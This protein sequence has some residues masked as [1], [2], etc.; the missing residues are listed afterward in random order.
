MLKL[1]L[2]YFGHLMWRT[3]SFEKSLVLGKIE[4]GRRRG[5]QRLRWL[6][7][8]T[9]SMDMSLGKLRELVIDREAWHAAV[10]GV[11]KSQT[12]L[13]DW[14]E[15][16]WN[17]SLSRS[18]IKH[19]KRAWQSTSVFL[20]GEYCGQRSLAGLQS[21]R[22]QRVRHDGSDWACTSTHNKARKAERV[23]GFYKGGKIMTISGGLAEWGRKRCYEKDEEQEKTSVISGG[24]SQWT[25][26]ILNTK[27]LE[28]VS[29]KDRKRW[30]E[31]GMLETG[32][33][34]LQSLIMTSSTTLTM[35]VSSCDR[36]EDKITGRRREIREN[37]LIMFFIFY[38]LRC[39][40]FLGHFNL[41]KDWSSQG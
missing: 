33:K 20:P 31:I 5:Q 14:T 6:D 19:W 4:G 37:V 29:Y 3:D 30:L 13:S 39:F 17:H 7:G 25:Q 11:T 1:K 22:S 34:K 10:H 15:L 26:R 12:R 9:E 27:V 18:M 40:D 21:I 2:Q 8:I 16:N 24:R 41:G 32:R 38:T 36:M 28:T 35:R 23:E